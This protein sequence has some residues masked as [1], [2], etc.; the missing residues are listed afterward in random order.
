MA[1]ETQVTQ[2]RTTTSATYG[3]PGLFA[4]IA[5]LVGFIIVIIIVIWGL[6]HLASLLSPWFTSNLS[7]KA[8]SALTVQAPATVTSGE[9]FPIAWNYNTSAT[10]I[11]AFIY[12]CSQSL[13]FE[14]NGTQGAMNAIPCGAAFSVSGNS[15]SLTPLLSGSAT[16]SVPLTIVFTPSSGTR[17]QASANVIVNPATV[18]PVVITR[19][20]PVATGPAD[21]AVTMVSATVDQNGFGTVTFDISNIGSGA[22]GVYT[23]SAFLPTRASYTYYSPVQS[24]LAP[25][26]HII[27][28]LHFTQGIP[29][30]VSVI[31]NDTNDTNQANNYTGATM[32]APY[33]YAPQPSYQYTVQPTPYVY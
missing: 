2:T 31:V 9:A 24:S 17:V 15:L 22:S 16:T 8:T 20:T 7:T 12:P 28:T 13:T 6:I 26:S 3:E 21:L 1:E 11:Y 5:A 25:G 18:A 27:D 4:R 10:G 14:T 32:S 33:G 29:G 30:A 23:F 19:P